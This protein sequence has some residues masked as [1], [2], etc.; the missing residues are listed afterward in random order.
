MTKNI[1]IEIWISKDLLAKIEKHV[2]GKDTNE[3]IVKC[4]TKY[5]DI[6]ERLT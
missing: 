6:I 4:L 2:E 5:C 1:D 3:K